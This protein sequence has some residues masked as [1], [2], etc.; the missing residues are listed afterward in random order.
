MLSSP[1]ELVRDPNRTVTEKKTLKKVTF[2]KKPSSDGYYHCYIKD[3]LKK[4]G[5]R[6]IKAKTLE[7]LQKKVLTY[8]HGESGEA[9]KTFREA[10]GILQARTGD[11]VKTRERHYSVSN[12]VSRHWQTYNRFFA[13]TD[14]EKLHVDEITELDIDA[15]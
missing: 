6:Q 13:G 3:P 15:G 7:E 14:F 8:E 9:R 5:R 1:P 12:T 11:L 2:P 10:Y 4:S